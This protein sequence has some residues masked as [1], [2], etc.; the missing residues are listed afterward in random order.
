MSA[1]WREDISTPR[2]LIDLAD[3][4]L[5][6]AKRAGRNRVLA[7]GSISNLHDLDRADEKGFRRCLAR[8]PAADVM[9]TPM[10]TLSV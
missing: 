5:L 3:E 1:E 2:Q 10:V 8:I 4:A 7:Y 6:A 9:L